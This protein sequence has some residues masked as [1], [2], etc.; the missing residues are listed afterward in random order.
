MATVH[1]LYF[2]AMK[3]Q[4]EKRKVRSEKRKGIREIIAVKGLVVKQ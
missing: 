4:R 1:P 3:S 2:R